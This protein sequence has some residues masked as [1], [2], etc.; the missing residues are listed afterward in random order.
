MFCSYAAIIG[1]TYYVNKDVSKE[2]KTV[3]NSAAGGFREKAADLKRVC[4]SQRCPLECSQ[5]AFMLLLSKVI[6]RYALATTE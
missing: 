4:E 6:R 3:M 5:R 2:I 1:E